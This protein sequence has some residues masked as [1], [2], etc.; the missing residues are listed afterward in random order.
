MMTKI[1]AVLFFQFINNEIL[2]MYYEMK[3]EADLAINQNLF[4]QLF[5]F[6]L[7]KDCILYILFQNNRMNVDLSFNSDLEFYDGKT[8][9]LIHYNSR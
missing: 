4:A 3:L 8:A 6:F 1:H 9:N 7:L 2:E 5:Y